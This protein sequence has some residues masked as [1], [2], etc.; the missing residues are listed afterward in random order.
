MRHAHPTTRW[1]TAALLA[2][3]GLTL[4]IRPATAQDDTPADQPAEAQPADADG[5]N[6]LFADPD[7]V[8]GNADA[9]TPRVD[10]EDLPLGETVEFDADEALFRFHAEEP[11]ILTLLTYTPGNGARASLQLQNPDGRAVPGGVLNGNNVNNLGARIVV[12][13]RGNRQGVLPGFV[14]TTVVVTEPG[15]Y[16]LQVSITG[17]TDG[18]PSVGGAWMPFEQVGGFERQQP[19]APPPPPVVPPP[20]PVDPTE[21]AEQ[22][23]VGAGMELEINNGSGWVKLTAEEPGTLVFTSRA[24]RGDVQLMLY[25]EDDLDNWREYANHDRN[26]MV[27]HEALLF[28]SDAGEV[29]YIQVNASRG[30]VPVFAGFIPDDLETLDTDDADEADNDADAGEAAAADAEDTAEPAPAGDPPTGQ[31]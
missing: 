13:A 31:E 25:A 20:P 5:D 2:A 16:Q 11:G 9:D 15:E 27:G 28:H 18:R 26:G 24:N 22:L 6:G 3:L 29:W 7:V 1:T 4:A 8:E 30:E 14:Y 19:V 17:E 21:A 23:A 10:A 12:D